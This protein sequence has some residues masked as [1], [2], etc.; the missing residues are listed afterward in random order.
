VRHLLSEIFAEGGERIMKA[1]FICWLLVSL[2]WL[3]GGPSWSAEPG[4]ATPLLERSEDI[5]TALMAYGF[6]EIR[7][8]T[9][10]GG[11]LGGKV[12]F[13]E[14]PDSKPVDL[15]AA[16]LDT[17]KK[18]VAKGERLDPRTVSGVLII[19]IKRPA[20][21]DAKGRPCHVSITVRN[22]IVRED[23]KGNKR[24]EMT[25]IMSEIKGLVPAERTSGAF[26]ETSSGAG[27]TRP[28]YRARESFT[29]KGGKE[30][31]LYELMLKSSPGG[32]GKADE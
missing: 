24:S 21:D 1:T 10:R 13:L 15:S 20:A 4:H 31:T 5:E 26:V 14:G 11:L 8:F 19:A 6:A 3:D 27:G 9:W 25:R 30:F 7:V 28:Q 16:I 29:L 17:A 23:G 12:N 22:Q 32:G 2:A 18:T